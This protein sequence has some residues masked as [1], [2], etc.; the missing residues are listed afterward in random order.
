MRTIAVVN[1]KG[2]CGKT[3]TAV[4]M[5]AAFGELGKRVLLVDFD[6]QAHATIGL[7]QDPDSLKQ[8]VYDC[9]IDPEV[10][11]PGIIVPCDTERLHLLPGSVMLSSAELEL[12]KMP[13]KDLRLA[14]VLRRVRDTYDVCVIDSSASVG[15][16]TLN[17]LVTSSDV[18]VPVQ[19]HYYALE[20]LK[21]LLETVRFIRERF[22][23]YSMENIRLLLTF[24]EERAAFSRKIQQ[25]LRDIFGDLVLDTVIHRDN[26][27]AEAPGASQSILG[28][29]P[30]SKGT[31]DYR[32]LA[33]EML[34]GSP[35]TGPVAVEKIRKG[36][37]KHLSTL[38]EGVWIP[39]GTRS[40]NPGP[41][42]AT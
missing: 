10:P 3:T 5:A 41:I 17:A 14:R 32:A 42:D 23:P 30:R 19:V 16:L 6:P 26:H 1:Q 13:D 35:R 40:Y 7:G 20:G 18:V 21:R 38:F 34:T 25:Q 39:E 15:L 29:A 28:Y 22:H 4:N 33:S 24:V 37:Q 9:L 8:S 11:T 27:L 36:I 31:A 2:G 12:A